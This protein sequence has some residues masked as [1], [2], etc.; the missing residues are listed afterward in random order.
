MI[1]INYFAKIN[2]KTYGK[3]MINIINT[4]HGFK[5]PKVTLLYQF[6]K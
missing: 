6:D 3:L 5:G 2:P 4:K 1:I